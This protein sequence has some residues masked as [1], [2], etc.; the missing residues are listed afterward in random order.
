T[1]EIY[2]VGGCINRAKGDEVDEMIVKKIEEA[3]KEGDSVGGVISCKATGICAGI[4]SPIFDNVESRISAVI[5]SI[6]GVKGLEFG[7][8]FAITEKKGWEVNDCFTRREERV[9]TKTN[10][11][12]GIMGGITTGMPIELK[13]AIKPTPSI[14][15]GQSTLNVE[16]GKEERLSIQ[17]RHDPCIALRAPVVVEA[18][19][20]IALMDLYLEAY[21]Y[22]TR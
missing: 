6:P 19:V 7:D 4:G 11:S 18:A 10:H 9:E 13:V 1:G 12:G 21:G 22:V 8:G 17:G 15:K 20:A 14:S 5:Y 2:S 16:T 3:M